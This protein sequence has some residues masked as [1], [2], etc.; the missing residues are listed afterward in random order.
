M[1]TEITVPTDSDWPARVRARAHHNVSKYESCTQSIVAAFLG[2]L[3]I[4]DPLV[5]RATG[6]LH[7]GMVSS[8][9]CGIVSGAMI[10][11][12]LL[13]G[14]EKL[15]EGLDGIFPIV[16]PGQDLVSRLQKRLG[17]LS[18]REISG[19]DF[20]DLEQAMKFI[21]SGEN[22]RCFDH[23]AAGAE[24]IACFL[25]ELGAKG[26]LFRIAESK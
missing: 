1:I 13:I 10:V 8:L 26:E 12:G 23:V 5:L 24:E 6:G 22:A 21:S 20:T 16:I 18:C 17:S 25:Q 2:E 3:G 7:G 9:T 14:R 11:L 19:V 4:D 15:E